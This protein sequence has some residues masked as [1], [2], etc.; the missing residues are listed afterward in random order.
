MSELAFEIEE[1]DVEKV[2]SLNDS[3]RREIYNSKLGLLHYTPMVSALND[4]D[5][6]ELTSLVQQFEDFNEDNDP[7]GEHDFG[8]IDFRGES[9]FFKIDYYDNALKYHSPDKSNPK[10]TKR[11]L[12]LMNTQEY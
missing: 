9:Y 10:L 11:V 1:I 3:F 2:K 7:Y 4:E 6:F 5:R 8:K 12:T